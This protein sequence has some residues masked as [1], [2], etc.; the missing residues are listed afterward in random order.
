MID[1]TDF[2]L[3][4]QGGIKLTQVFLQQCLHQPQLG[5]IHRCQIFL[6]VLHLSDICNGSGDKTITRNWQNYCPLESEFKWPKTTKPS[7]TDWHTWNTVNTNTFQV[8]CYLNLHQKLGMFYP[9]K[10]TS[11]FYDPEEQAIWSNQNKQWQQHSH[12]LARSCTL[13]FHKQG[14]VKDT[15][16]ACLHQATVQVQDHKIFLMGSAPIAPTPSTAN[17]IT[18]LLHHPFACTWQWETLVV[19]NLPQLINDLQLGKGYAV[20]DRSFQASKG[21]AMWIIKGV[22]NTNHIVGMGCSPSDSEGHSSFCSK[23]ASIFAIMF[24][25]Q[26]LLP[27]MQR[28]PTLW[29]ACD[30]KSVLSWLK[31]L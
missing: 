15:P 3:N 19:G 22:D 8:D 10:H 25:L 11:W 5:A 16:H 20:S 23:L 31:W 9:N 2:P 7:T 12:I 26:T 28:Q 6:K 24:T 29:L 18:M 14:E 30:G 21:A 13:T 27:K 17:A 1:I 4:Q